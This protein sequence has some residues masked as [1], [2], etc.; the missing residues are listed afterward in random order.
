MFYVLNA[1]DNFIMFYC[2]ECDKELSI[3]ECRS[4]GILTSYNT[5]L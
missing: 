4:K 1:T 3:S 5:D 2:G